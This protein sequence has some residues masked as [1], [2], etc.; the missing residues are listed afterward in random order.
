[1]AV[2]KISL[3]EAK[4][5]GK[6]KGSLRARWSA[7][8]RQHIWNTG[9]KDRAEAM[10]KATVEADRRLARAGGSLPETTMPA[11]G[12]PRP[13][14][15]WTPPPVTSSPS[16]ST[17]G[18][19]RRPLA[20]AFGRA[21]TPTAT[22]APPLLT[23]ATE[24]AVDELE[25]R[26]Q[27]TRKLYE[28]AAKAGTYLLEGGLKRAVRFA[29]REPDDMDDDEQELIR[30]GCGELCAQW[31]GRVELG[32]GG[33]VAV[34]CIVAGVGM[35]MGGTPIP[36]PKALPPAPPHAQ[37]APPREDPTGDQGGGG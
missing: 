19:S 23:P 26:K 28:V 7:D 15:A 24:A 1:M 4:K 9:T 37:P 29:G 6:P 32:P 35:Y 12:P 22:P 11:A 36:K 16:S 30:E 3:F 8:G 17:N 18:H 34:G 5:N 27:K 2:T 31:F 14:Q 21:L 10:A 13:S 33:K 25:E 20:E